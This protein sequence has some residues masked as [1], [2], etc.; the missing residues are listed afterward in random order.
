MST[1]KGL[2]LIE[3]IVAASILA[4]GLVIV[5]RSFL[6]NVAALDRVV[7]K[8]NALQVLESKIV[9]LEQKVKEE[10]RFVA[11]RPGE[12]DVRVGVRPATLTIGVAPVVFE[13]E[14]KEE[15][16]DED[17]EPKQ[18]KIIV[19]I[20]KVELTLQWEEERQEREQKLVTCF[21]FNITNTTNTT[22]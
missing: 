17:G 2:T 20:D 13:E 7:N 1:P 8:I 19:N 6:T 14:A 9:E 10:G 15:D 5:L 18:E 3:L 16:P 11:G 22:E 12:E 4:I 21:A